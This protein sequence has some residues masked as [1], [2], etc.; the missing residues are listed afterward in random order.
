MR[1]RP[2]ARGQG[3]ASGGDGLTW[4][5][6]TRSRAC[7]RSRACGGRAARSLSPRSRACSAT[8]PRSM[9]AGRG[10]SRGCQ[11]LAGYGRVRG[12]AAAFGEL[13]SSATEL[14]AKLTKA[15]QG[16][17]PSD[18]LVAEML[19][20][21]SIREPGSPARNIRPG[22][23]E[24]G[25]RPAPGRPLERR[26]QVLAVFNAWVA[27]R[28]RSLEHNTVMLEAWMRA[29]G[30]FA[31]EPERDAPK[32]PRSSSP[33]ARCSTLWVETAKRRLL[34]TQRSRRS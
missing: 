8:W 29:A 19:G 10:R 31:K 20:R 6:W 15:M 23:A 11:A 24:H 30:A 5:R 22:A 9:R 16:S 4:R 2:P 21:S 14:S 25:R 33:G 27:L 17:A 26:A 3:R 32:R 34:E 1:L 13:W 28:R 18:P 12:G 7:A